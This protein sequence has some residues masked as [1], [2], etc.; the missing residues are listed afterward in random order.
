MAYI[1]SLTADAS[2]AALSALKYVG[3]AG[4]VV[5]I[6][7]FIVTSNVRWVINTPLL[8]NYG[9]N[10]YDIADRTGIESDQLRNA[11]KQ[12]RDYFNNQN[13]FLDVRVIQLGILRSIYNQREILHMK[14]VKDL[15]NAVYTIQEVTGLY[16]ITFTLIGVALMRRRFLPMLGLLISFGGILTLALVLLVAIGSLVGFTWLFRAF[17]MISFSNDLWQLDP[18]RDYLIAMF[19]ESFFLDATMWIAG[20]TLVLALAMAT[21]PPLLLGWRPAYSKFKIGMERMQNVF[22]QV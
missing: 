20:S 15:V 1:D 3:L 9:F 6:P 17:H 11:G 13:E 18:N 2:K 16:L 14:D 7:V 4:F 21:V 22:R 12:I 10:Q 5:A 8:Y 19:P